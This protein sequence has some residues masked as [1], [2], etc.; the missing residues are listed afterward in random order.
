MGKAVGFDLGVVESLVI[1]PDL[2]K[3]GCEK[4]YSKEVRALERSVHDNRLVSY[5]VDCHQRN[6]K[7]HTVFQDKEPCEFTDVVFT[8]VVAHQFQHVLEHN[9]LFDIV[10]VPPDVIVTE[11][12]SLFADSWKYGWPEVEY[13]GDLARLNAVLVERRI[14]GF[15]VQSSL[16]CYG[17]VLAEACER[18]TSD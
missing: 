16:G 13:Q 12:Q 6:I 17:W 9:I 7:L 18:V 14:K 4:R 1:R 3:S 2:C 15:R 8:G 10:E 5:L 11:H